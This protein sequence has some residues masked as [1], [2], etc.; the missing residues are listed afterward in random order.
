VTNAVKH[1][2]FEQ[3]GKQRLHTKPNAGEIQFCVWWLG[4]ELDLLRP[5]PALG[6]TAAYV[7]MGRSVGLK[8][9]RGH[10]LQAAN[11]IQILVTIHPSYLLRIR[12][13]DDHESRGSALSATSSALATI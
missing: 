10:V 4:G 11:I 3:R 9:E 1:F 12:D 7:L 13:H 5:D 2:K 8:K 6:A